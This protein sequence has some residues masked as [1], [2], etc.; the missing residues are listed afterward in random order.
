M[1]TEAIVMTDSNQQLE[2][3]SPT[4]SWC[5][6]YSTVLSLWSRECF[7]WRSSS[8]LLCFLDHY[9]VFFSIQKPI[10]S[11][12]RS[13][14]WADPRQMVLENWR[15]IFSVHNRC[16][17]CGALVCYIDRV[18]CLW[19]YIIRKNGNFSCMWR[20]LL[21]EFWN[22]GWWFSWSLGYLQL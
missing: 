4:V 21:S 17:M 20:L 10:C 18:Q 19:M 22:L 11:N 5:V 15:I 6:Q 3:W 8:D 13:L 14:T 9:F 1:P 12:R 7:F 2:L 16:N